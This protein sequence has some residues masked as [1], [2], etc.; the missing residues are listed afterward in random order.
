MARL[1]L[2]VSAEDHVLVLTVHHI[3]ADGWSMQVMVDEFSELY[4]AAVEGQ[5]G[6]PVGLPVNYSDYARWQRDWL[7]AGEGARQLAWWREQLAGSQAPL[8]L[9][10]ELTR[11]ARRSERGASLMLNIDRQ[12]LA[13]LRERAHEQQ[14]TLFMLLLASFQALLHRQSGQSSISVGVP[15]AGRSRLE[16]EGLIGLFINTQVLRAEID[17]QQTVQHVAATGQAMTRIGRAGSPGLAV[18]ATGRCPAT[19]PQPQS[20]PLVPGALQPSA[21]AGREC[22][23]QRRPTCRSSVC[24]GSDTPRNSI[25][26]S[27]PREQGDSAGRQP[28]LRH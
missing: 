15:S 11:P 23:A 25:W 1:L 16:T 9:P 17:G 6:Q 24:T 28:D 21:A 3:A 5:C 10:S 14:V 13:G 8:E 4:Q 20:Q 7:E 22:R 27:I 19:G 26:C 18:R 2:H 12:L